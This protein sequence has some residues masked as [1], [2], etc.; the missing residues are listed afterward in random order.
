MG[1]LPEA[2]DLPMEEVSSDIR[3]MLRAYQEHRRDLLSDAEIRNKKNQVAGFM[4]QLRVCESELEEL[5]RPYRE[6]MDDLE[7]GI[8][9]LGIESFTKSFTHAGIV[10]RFRNGSQRTAWKGT[11]LK[12]LLN[13]LQEEGELR[14][15]ERILTARSVTAIAPKI[16]I[17]K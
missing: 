6:K 2:V 1:K 5:E 13:E 14:M 10:V 4:S 15:A 3:G 11:I 7:R 9:H 8:E 16:K 12:E 17:E